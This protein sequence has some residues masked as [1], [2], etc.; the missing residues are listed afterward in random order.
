MKKLKLLIIPL[1][2]IALL[3][4]GM[5]SFASLH[6]K[7]SS[8]D[9]IFY[10][11]TTDIFA[12]KDSTDGL[13]V[14]DDMNLTFG[15]NSDATIVYDETT[16]DKLEITCSNGITISGP[17]DGVVILDDGTIA[18]GTGSDITESWDNTRGALV[19]TPAGHFVSPE[20]I[21]DRFRLTWVAGA[22]GKP[23][24]NADIAPASADDANDGATKAEIALMLASDQ[25]FEV[26]G[27]NASSDDVT[28]YAEG[29]IDL[30]T[31]GADGDGVIILPHLDSNQTGWSQITWGTDKEVRWECSIKTGAA[32]TTCII[33]AGL[34]LTNTDVVITDADQAYFRYEDG[35][36]DGEWQAVNSIADTDDAHDTN[37]AVAINTVYH[38]V[39]EIDSSRVAKFYINGALVETSTALTDAVD[40]IPYIAIEEDGAGAAMTL[41]VRG[42]AISRKFE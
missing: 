36:N 30:E 10:D 3:A 16:D 8:G 13:M 14:Y 1:L 27:T 2:I 37:V 33:W 20:G 42:Q 15:D 31:D 7:W 38:L 18:Y 4:F 28:Y 34:K 6:S 11:G 35:I 21:S 12:I 17:I 22:K 24:L 25:N 19:T 29:G 41:Y 40:L 26:L 5:N 39:I 9:L 32:I 23:G